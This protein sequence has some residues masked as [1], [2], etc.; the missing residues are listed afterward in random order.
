MQKVK[1]QPDKQGHFGPYGGMFVPETLMSALQEL[2]AEYDRARRDAKFRR[3]LGYCLREYAGRP[4]RLWLA[5]RM[6]RELGGARIYLKREDMLHTGAHKIN[7]CLGQVLLARRLGKRRIIAETGAGQHGVATATVAAMF[8]LECVIYMG[9]VDMVRQ[10]LN[11]YRMRLLGAKVVGVSAGQRTLKEAISEAMRDWTTNVRTTHY[12]LGSAL[13]SHPYPM[14][15]RDFQSCIGREARRQILAKEGRLPDAIVACVGGGSNSIGIFHP[16]LGDKKV[17]L[18]GVE[19]GGRGIKPGN[20]AARF[21]GGSLG[22]L[23]G[24]RTYVLQNADGQIELTH[25]VSAGLDYAAVGPEHAW[26]RDLKRV[27]YTYA[28]DDEALRAFKFLAEKEGI[29]PAL[30][31]AHAVAHTMKLAPKM[32][33]NQIV[34]I[35]LSGRGDKDVQQVAEIVKL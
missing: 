21:A 26:L 34:I 2:A 25:S 24:T 9:E 33:K 11:V 7:N 10:A 8:G 1:S 29:I 14:M 4:T 3:E 16:F 12:I 35:N 15:V 28:T 32:K 6:T 19:A 30:E 27:E 23:Q 5:E 20:H 17:R 13:G 22:V 31:S 18:I